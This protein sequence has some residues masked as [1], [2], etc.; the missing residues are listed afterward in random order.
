[1]KRSKGGRALLV[2]LAL[3]GCG[4]PAYDAAE[5]VGD[6]TEPIQLAFMF[7]GYHNYVTNTSS[8]AQARS[9]AAIRGTNADANT[10]HASCGATFVSPHYAVTAA[11]CVNQYALGSTFTVEAFK[12]VNLDTNFIS[13]TSST[14]TGTWPTWTKGPNLTSSQGWA[15][16]TY[17]C[18]VVRRCMSTEGGVENC[19]PGVTPDV[20]I[21]MIHCPGRSATLPFATTQTATDQNR[22]VEV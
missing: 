14:V 5:E 10:S 17:S 9:T 21:A 4:G 7:A 6:Q 13:F 18:S 12:T 11:H 19:P 3:W 8:F 15:R 20:D 16:T 2:G 22:E 1:M